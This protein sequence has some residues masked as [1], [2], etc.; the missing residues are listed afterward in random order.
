MDPRYPSVT[1]PRI[2]PPSRASNRFGP[3]AAR[4]SASVFRLVIV[5]I[6]SRAAAPT[7]GHHK[8]PDAHCT[9][10]RGHGR[11]GAEG[12]PA[13]E[14]IS[15]HPCSLIHMETPPNDDVAGGLPRL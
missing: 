2:P 9:P 11:L 4:R 8:L 10:I 5:A 14:G 13:H 1:M 12:R 3:L 6:P 15:C 7:C